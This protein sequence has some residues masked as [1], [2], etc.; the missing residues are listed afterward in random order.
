MGGFT[1]GQFLG[2]WYFFNKSSFTSFL[3]PSLRI[4][5]HLF[6]RSSDMSGPHSSDSASRAPKASKSSGSTGSTSSSSVFASGSVGVTSAAG[7]ADGG[8]AGRVSASS[9]AHIDVTT[10]ASDRVGD[11][12]GQDKGGGDSSQDSRSS[13]SARKNKRLISRINSFNNCFW[14]ISRIDSKLINLYGIISRIISE[15]IK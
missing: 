8:R 12:R 11:G 15:K 5:S 2:H 4:G 6:V 13:E 7:G 10:D 9:G 14:S 1:K 3:S